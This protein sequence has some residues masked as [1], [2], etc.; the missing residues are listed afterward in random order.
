MSSSIPVPSRSSATHTN[1]SSFSD[2]CLFGKSL[3]SRPKTALHALPTSPPVGTNTHYSTQDDFAV[4]SV[5]L[6]S[7]GARRWKSTG[8]N[9]ATAHMLKKFGPWDFSEVVTAT[10]EVRT[11]LLEG[12]AI[13]RR[14]ARSGVS[15]TYFFCRQE[16][17]QHAL[18]VFK[19]MDE[20]AESIDMSPPPSTLSSCPQLDPIDL[21]LG[22]A[23]SGP[24]A[25]P[26]SSPTRFFNP[27]YT[28]SVSSD[29]ETDSRTLSRAIGFQQGE[30]A[31]REVAA[32][33]LDHDRFARV[34]QTALLQWLKPYER[35]HKDD[36]SPGCTTSDETL[37]DSTLNNSEHLNYSDSEDEGTTSDSDN[38][39]DDFE[40]STGDDIHMERGEVNMQTKKGAFQVFVPNLGDADDFGPGVFNMDQVHQI[41]VL[42][43]RTLNHDRHGGNILVTNSSIK[44]QRYDLVPI[45]HGY[46]LPDIIQSVPWP[47]WMDWPMIRK[48]LSPS[49]R[50]Y[51]ECLDA[52]S[53]VRRLTN[54]LNGIFR[55]GALQGLKIATALLQKGIAAGLT[56]YDVGLLMY[57]RRDEPYER[58]EL[59]KIVN[60]A[61]EASQARERHIAEQQ[62]LAS[63]EETRHRRHPSMN[64]IDHRETFVDEYVVK[65]ATRRIQELVNHVAAAKVKAHSSHLARVRS[66][67]DFAIGEKPVHALLQRAT[68]NTNGNVVPA[69]SPVG[70]PMPMGSPN[71]CGLP[72]EACIPSAPIQI[73][74][75]DNRVVRIALPKQL[76]GNGNITPTRVSRPVDIGGSSRRPPIAPI[77]SKM[78]QK[79]SPISPMDTCKW[80][81]PSHS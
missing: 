70:S 64:A 58:S 9:T 65:Y 6:I 43:I 46:I 56:L 53:D 68:S 57:I 47:V 40:G 38:S 77:F 11:A 29:S 60:E 44:G 37:I 20:E 5:E 72:L 34:P 55:P 48:P 16:D 50:R 7:R 69:S 81:P 54:E 10:D 49:V 51:I 12:A 1:T 67:P 59:E 80:S 36:A 76:G 75:N 24:W 28:A 33:L 32:Y 3:P 42:D 39:L 21:S 14:P 26:A 63:T 52:E 18:G 79:T 13:A 8:A 4:P 23:H 61:E 78:P 66:I 31:Y 71:S 27:N 45:D 19:P 22:P 30:G 15:G 41:A 25:S 62:M 17:E 2:A 74:I 35:G 73:P